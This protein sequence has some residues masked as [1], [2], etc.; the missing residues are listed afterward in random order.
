MPLGFGRGIFYKSAAQKSFL[1]ILIRM[2]P[3]VRRGLALLGQP[4]HVRGRSVAALRQDRHFSAVTSFQIAVS[5]ERRGN[6][7]KYGRL[8]L[9]VT[10]NNSL[11]KRP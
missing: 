7:T 1:P 10:Y 9:F 6:G 4:E 11:R 8:P 2:N 5:R 3:F